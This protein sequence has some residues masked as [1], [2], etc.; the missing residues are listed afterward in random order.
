MGRGYQ[1]AVLNLLRAPE[2]DFEIL[3]VRQAGD[4]TRMRMHNADLLGHARARDLPPTIWVR[5]WVP[6]GDNEHQRAYTLVEI[7][8]DAAQCSIYLLHHE[9]DG[10]ASRWALSARPGDTIPAQLYGGTKYRAPASGA[11]LLLVGDPASAPAIADAL[12]AAPPSCA[13]DVVVQATD[14]TWLPLGEVPGTVTRVDPELGTGGLLDVVAGLVAEHAPDW[15]W[16]A[17]DSAATR[18]VRRALLDAGV[19]RAGI[20][21]QAYWLRGR[22]M[23]TSSH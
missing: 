21:H 13:A 8:Q 22:A 10:P 17:L 6:D 18:A 16:V 9:P 2:F 7:D 20:Q 14:D 19:P 12:A 5:L 15:A 3:D 1:G 11:R 4:Y 23:G